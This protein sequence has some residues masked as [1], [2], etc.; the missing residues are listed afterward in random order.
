MNALGIDE[1]ILGQNVGV[2]RASATG[3]TYVWGENHGGSILTTIEGDIVRP[4]KLPASSLAAAGWDSVWLV[5]DEGL[6]A[7]S[8]GH[9]SATV[10]LGKSQKAK[11]S[12]IF[13]SAFQSIFLRSDGSMTLHNDRKDVDFQ[14]LQLDRPVIQVARGWAHFLLLDSTGS[15]WSV[16]ANKHGQ[17]GLG[18]TN[19]VITYVAAH[20][21]RSHT[22]QTLTLFAPSPTL[23][24]QLKG[25]KIRQIASGATHSMVLTESGSVLMYA[26]TFFDFVCLAP[27]FR[28]SLTPT[29]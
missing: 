21:L 23:L 14:T 5:N 11:V 13:S 18:H 25:E 27:H 1:L 24:P 17:C 10:D 2:G 6:T 20:T 7:T 16:G 28:I 15:V 26:Q 12:K 29:L 8:L 4:Q 3:E 19:T 22:L 9:R